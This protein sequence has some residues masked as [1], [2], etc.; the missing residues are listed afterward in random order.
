MMASAGVLINAVTDRKKLLGNIRYMRNPWIT[1]QD[2][3]GTRV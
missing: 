2:G 1:A 3:G